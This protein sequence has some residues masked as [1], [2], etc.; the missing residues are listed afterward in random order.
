MCTSQLIHLFVTT[1]DGK[2]RFFITYVYAFN[3]MEGRKVLWTDLKRIATNEA[4]VILGDFNEILS[5]EERIGKKVK[6]NEATEFIDCVHC[7]QLEDIKFRGSY[8]TW[9]NKRQ[10]NERIWSKIDRV[11]ANRKWMDDFSNAQVAFMVEGLFDHTPLLSQFIP[12]SRGKSPFKY[13]RMW[14]SHP[15]FLEIV[16]NLKASAIGTKMFQLVYKLRML[17]AELKELNRREF[18]NIQEATNQAKEDL[19]EIQMK[20]Q[21]DPLQDGLLEQEMAARKKYSLLL[22]GL[23]SFLQQKSKVTWIKEGDEN[24]AIFHA[25]IRERRRQNSI[26]SIEDQQGIRVEDQNKITEAFLSFYYQLLGS[27]MEQR[28]QVMQSIMKQG[29]LVTQQQAE[30]LMKEYTKEDVKKAIFEIPGIK[31]PGPDGERGLHCG[32]PMSPL[33]FVLGMEYLSRIMSRIGSKPEFQY[34]DR[35]KE[36]KMNHLMFADDVILFC[37]GD[38]QSIHL[39]LQG[40]KLFLDFVVATEPDKSAFTVV[41]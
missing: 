14:S 21:A 32:D 26:L 20:I 11:L 29:P 3:D 13:F 33:L 27:K 24:S 10:G 12:N 17:K 41:A 25:S 36:L 23:S 18:S 40:L 30:R 19:V 1:L 2:H 6:Y 16:T 35:C 9:S 4:W 22:K 38:F 7:C 8:F 34:H 5:K 28:R 31:A 39:M 15:R 37:H